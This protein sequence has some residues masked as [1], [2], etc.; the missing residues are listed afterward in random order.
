M[1]YNRTAVNSITT[2]LEPYR[3]RGAGAD[4]QA[5]AGGL[6]VTKWVLG[7]GFRVTRLW[8]VLHWGAFNLYGGLEQTPE[9]GP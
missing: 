2:D 3:G 6:G 4:G 8:I 1:F 9:K 5:E 7:L